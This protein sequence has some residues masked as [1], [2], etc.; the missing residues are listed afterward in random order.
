MSVGTGVKQK[1][2]RLLGILDYLAHKQMSVKPAKVAEELSI[3]L[4][5]T[6]RYLNSLAD[7]GFVYKNNGSG[8]FGA[9]WLICKMGDAIKSSFSLRSFASSFMVE[10]ALTYKVATSLAV[11]Q[12]F[13]LVYLDFVDSPND[14]LRSFK[15]I[16]KDAP[17]YS[18]GSGKVMLSSLPYATRDRIIDDLS[19]E[20][21]ARK[22]ITDKDVLKREIEKVRGQKYAID[23]EECEDGYR[24]V[25]VPIVDY[26]GQII[27]A[28]SAIDTVDRMSNARVEME[29]LPAL[30]AAS[31]A[32]S[33][34]LGYVENVSE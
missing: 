4:S 24:C 12:D 15:R 22:T 6:I 5:T 8:E 26:S 28:I 23:D 13:K 27:A 11:L 18:T 3:P 20:T 1:D 25:C 16:G 7:Q 33:F 2:E 21:I 9:T 32:I 17:I 14:D 10:L 29:L 19:L 30:R 34:R 31:K